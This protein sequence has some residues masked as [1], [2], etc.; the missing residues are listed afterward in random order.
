MSAWKR[1]GLICSR[2][3]QSA[4]NC[5][6]LEQPSSEHSRPNPQFHNVH[7]SDIRRSRAM[8]KYWRTTSKLFYRGFGRSQTC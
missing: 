4:S 7:C 8:C 6:N 3:G 5:S 1:N 2:P